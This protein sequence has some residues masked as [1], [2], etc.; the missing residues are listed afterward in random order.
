MLALS[1][2]PAGRPAEKRATAGLPR[3]ETGLL[4]G[5]APPLP[6]T[7]P[8][9]RCVGSPAESGLANRQRP[10]PRRLACRHGE[11]RAGRVDR[12]GRRGAAR[13]VVGQPRHV[14]RR[15]A[16]PDQEGR[17]RHHADLAA[18][19]RRGPVLRL[20]RRAGPQTGRGDLLDPVHPSSIPQ[21]LVTAQRRPRG[22]AGSAGADAARG[23]RRGGRRESGRAVGG[24][25]RPAV[26]GRG[27]GRPPRRH[28]RR[29]GRPGHVR[30]AHQ[31]QP[32]RSHHRVNAVKRAETRERK[33][34]EFVA[35]LAR[36]ETFYPQKAKPPIRRSRPLHNQ[37]Y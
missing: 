22:P 29:P 7:S 28:R 27:A 2:P 6:P 26:G 24:G 5:W 8:G 11:R 37:A 34:G 25:L 4:E 20:D 30:R 13:V 21:L 14:A 36:H 32:V 23:P 17:H 15:L 10:R 31:G 18:G 12:R 3:V 35:M 33:I 9:G 1:P 19:G 16:G